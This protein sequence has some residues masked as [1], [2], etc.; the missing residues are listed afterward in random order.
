MDKETLELIKA[1]TP[2][3][4]IL[5]AALGIVVAPIA[6]LFG[7]W[8]G[9]FLTKRATKYQTIVEY[10]LRK[11]EEL[12]IAFAKVG[13]NYKDVGLKILDIKENRTENNK[14]KEDLKTLVDSFGED[15]LRL[16]VLQAIYSPELSDGP[17]SL[18][19][20]SEGL[21]KTYRDP[22]PDKTI[23]A[24]KSLHNETYRLV[25]QVAKSI[26]GVLE[27]RPQS[28]SQTKQGDKNA[29]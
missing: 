27:I 15:V 22:G 2:V 16:N 6:T 14:G 12:A 8:L 26:H 9:S 25:D 3:V 10:K 23:A 21:I 18:Q 13:E 1:L 24:M 28:R 4:A 20:L 5:M 29:S 11:L 17:D 19:K 7:I